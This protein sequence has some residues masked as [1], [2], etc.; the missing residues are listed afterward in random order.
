MRKIRLKIL[1][2]KGGESYLN[3]LREQGCIIGKDCYIASPS[4][5]SIDRSRPYLIQIGDNVRLNKGLTIMTHDFSSVVFKKI[6]GEMLP[7][8]GKVTIG[9]NVYF[10]WHCT[11]LKGVTIGDNCIIGYGSTV[12]HDI[13]ANSVAVG[14]P[15]KVICTIE[16]YYERRKVK[17]LEESLALAREIKNT[18]KRDPKPSDFKEEFVWFVNGDEF[19]KYPEI[20]IQHQL[21]VGVDCFNY[22]KTNHKA[23]FKDFDD[24]LKAAGL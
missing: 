20:P 22:W 17:S 19:D 4:T 2:H 12:M 16:E 1:I 15:A 21:E 23:T 11:V 3:F 5:V 9:N 14:T 13:P 6:Y 8:S 18:L 10:G 24:F 7:S